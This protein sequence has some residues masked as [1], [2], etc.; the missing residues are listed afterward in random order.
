MD[1]DRRPKD[2]FG[3]CLFVLIIIS[4][5]IIAFLAFIFEILVTLNIF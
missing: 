3:D 2:S 4:A 1:S 5:L